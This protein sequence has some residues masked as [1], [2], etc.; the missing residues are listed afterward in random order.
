MWALIHLFILA[1]MIYIPKAQWNH[2]LLTHFW[3]LDAQHYSLGRWRGMWSHYRVN[4]FVAQR[5]QGN[6]TRNP[7]TFDPQHQRPRKQ[8]RERSFLRIQLHGFATANHINKINQMRYN[9]NN[10]AH[11]HRPSPSLS[12]SKKT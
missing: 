3:R 7:V 10:R 1:C 12:L 11:K 8:I 2:V 6:A 4:V 5:L 9:D